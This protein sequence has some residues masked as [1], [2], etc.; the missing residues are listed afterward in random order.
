MKAIIFDMDGLMVDSER[1]YHQVQH[2]IAGR[3]NKI[4]P[5]DTRQ[6]MMGR[7]PL[8][9]LRIFVR[10]LSIS[11]D[12]NKV[13]QLRNTIMREKYKKELEL[14][15]GLIQII[16]Y[17]YGKLKLA[18]A[19]GAQLEFL[20]IVVDKFG[21]RNKFEVL[22]ASDDIERG[23]PDPEIYLKTCKRLG[24]KPEDCIVLEDSLNG[25]LAGKNAGCYVIA[26]PEEEVKNSDFTVA[27]FVAED[28][29]AAKRK[30]KDLVFSL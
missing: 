23:K 8:E 21:I 22:Q 27:D 2:E 3:Y 9:S 24:F 1:L 20:D 10:E 5:E 13:L 17:F 29:F 25:V 12:A 19:T 28:L 15:P 30:I 4:L 11:D 18:I 7:K 14:M 16:N 26:V 6:N